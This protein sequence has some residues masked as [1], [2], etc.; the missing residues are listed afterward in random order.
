M[1]GRQLL[2]QLLRQVCFTVTS[3]CLLDPLR[4]L[5]ILDGLGVDLQQ[6]VPL[7]LTALECLFVL[8]LMR[9]WLYVGLLIFKFWKQQLGANS[10]LV[11]NRR[12][13]NR[14]LRFCN[15]LDSV[16]AIRA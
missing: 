10:I 11:L 4:W 6:G 14:Q 9:R 3:P 13:L 12:H 8:A 5:I 15:V 1:R 7:K 2:N 16:E